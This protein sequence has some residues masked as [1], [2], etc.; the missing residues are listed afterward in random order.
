MFLEYNGCGQHPPPGWVSKFLQ[1]ISSICV[2]LCVCEG[3]MSLIRHQRIHARER[4][5]ECFDVGDSFVAAPHSLDIGQIPLEKGLISAANV[6]N[7]CSKT[8]DLL[9]TSKFMLIQ[10]LIRTANMGDFPGVQ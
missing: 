9:H 3:T 4:P 5:Y 8:P 6:R 2:R 1:N 7:F 10:G